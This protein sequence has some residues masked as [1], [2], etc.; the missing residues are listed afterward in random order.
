MKVKFKENVFVGV[1]F[2]R[3]VAGNIA[4][5][6]DKEAEELE[7]GGFIE[8]IQDEEKA[9]ESES[10]E[11]ETD[12]IPEEKPEPVKEKSYNKNGKRR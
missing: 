8:L 3:F 2:T 5:I 4:D 10:D 1:G 12:E 6:D 11:A 7:K 9:D